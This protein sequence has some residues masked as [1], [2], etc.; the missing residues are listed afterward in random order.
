MILVRLVISSP[1]YQ[2]AELRSIS[3]KLITTGKGD[4]LSLV[5]RNKTNDV[6]KN[7]KRGEVTE[8]MEKLLSEDFFQAE[9]QTST[10]RW[11]LALN[12]GPNGKLKSKKIEAEVDKNRSHDKKKNRLISGSSYLAAL[13]IANEDGSISPSKQNKFK[14]INRY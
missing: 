14:Q 1:A 10:T 5:F 9:L 6:T 3:G 8:L 2:E 7:Y 12:A 13:G 11:H 4:F